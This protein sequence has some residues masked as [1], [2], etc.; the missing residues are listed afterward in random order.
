MGIPPEYRD[1]LFRPFSPGDGS[2]SR[3][4]S[5]LG[6]GLAISRE[7]VILMG[8][9]IQYESDP[10]KGTRFWFTLPKL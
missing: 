4:V 9:Q 6:L 10:G 8:G 3:P 5:G 2:A 1:A 7:L